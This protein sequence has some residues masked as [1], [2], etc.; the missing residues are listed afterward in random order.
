MLDPTTSYTDVSGR[1]EIL[2]GNETHTRVYIQHKPPYLI[3]RLS[4]PDREFGVP[5]SGL[6]LPIYP[7]PSNSLV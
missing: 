3:R 4:L 2:G 5:N 7:V 6:Y 1:T